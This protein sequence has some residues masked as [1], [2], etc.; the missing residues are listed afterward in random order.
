LYHLLETRKN[1]YIKLSGFYRLSEVP[2]LDKHILHLLKIAPDQIV[3][4]SD[5]P[6]T[7][8]PEAN[9]NGDPQAIQ[10]FLTPDIPGFIQH[11]IELCGHDEELIRK[12]WVDN[13]RKLWDYTAD[14]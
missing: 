10:D 3:W 4:A 14:D 2:E 12:I 6:H 8:G 13:P 9:P 1:A 11:C 7:A 5:W